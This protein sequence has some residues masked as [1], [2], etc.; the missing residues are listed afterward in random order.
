LGLKVIIAK[1]FARIHFQNLANFGILPLVFIKSDDY[2]QI[3][4]EDDLAINN[5]RDTLKR[6]NIIKVTNQSKNVTFQ[7]KHFMSQRQIEM[8]MAGSLIN[9]VRN[10]NQMLSD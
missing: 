10:E 4:Q 2:D 9:M 6:S 7:V 5:I 8:V 3:S 1:S